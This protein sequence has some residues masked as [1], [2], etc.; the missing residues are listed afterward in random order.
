MVNGSMGNAG[1]GGGGG[2]GGSY[3]GGQG[4][5]TT[6]GHY[7][8]AVMAVG[9]GVT[10][11]V[12]APDSWGLGAF[13]IALGPCFIVMAHTRHRIQAWA[14]EKRRRKPGDPPTLYDLE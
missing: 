5:S 9:L 6:W 1:G 8:Y 14:K 3:Y 12:M 2:F 7:V 11:I 13:F 4:P 10:L